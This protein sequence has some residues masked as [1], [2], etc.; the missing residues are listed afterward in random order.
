LGAGDEVEVVAPARRLLVL[1]LEP[2][3]DLR[4]AALR[5]AASFEGAGCG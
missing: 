5:R 1:L 2:D 4:R 3:R